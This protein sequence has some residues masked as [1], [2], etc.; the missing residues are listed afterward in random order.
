MLNWMVESYDDGTLCTWSNKE[1]FVCTDAVLVFASAIEYGTFGVRNF[2]LLYPVLPWT[3]LMGT[4]IGVTWAL[5]QKYGPAWREHARLTWK[6]TR[7]EVWDK[8]LFSPF[9]YLGWFDPTVTWAGALTWSGGNNLTYATNGLYVSFIFMYYIKNRYGSWWEKYNYLLEAG[10][11]IGVAISGIVQ[12]FAFNF[13]GATI[14]WWGNSV[15]TAGLD[16]QAYNQNS[17]LLPLPEKGYF[18]LEPEDYPMSW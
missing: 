8:Y 6:E 17:T 14:D 3:F 15:G 2:F 16:Y 12:S 4:V 10:F 11:D 18:G 5:V 7:Y 1:H 13:T 9:S